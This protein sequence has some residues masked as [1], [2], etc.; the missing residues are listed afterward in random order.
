MS[1]GLSL[2]LDGLRVF[3]T[4][5]VVLSHLAYPRF[6]RGDYNI[7][8]EWNIGSDAVI[9]FF[10]ISGIV[11]AYAAERDG[12]LGQF[13]FK[14]L[15]RLWSV[16]L[17]ALLLTLAFDRLGYPLDPTA[18]PAPFFQPLGLWEMLV[19]GLS[20]T[21][22]WWVPGRLRLGS[23]GP[24]WSLSYE[25][26]Y[27]AL[28]GASVFLSGWL[29]VAVVLSLCL[30][31][32][33]LVLLLMP[34][35]LIGVFLWQRLRAGPD[36]LPSPPLAVIL[37]LAAPLAYV[38]AVSIDVPDL[39]AAITGLAFVPVHHSAVL[40]FSD[41]APWN[42]IIGALAAIH[43]LGMASLLAR[44]R[45]DGRWIRWL[46]GA[47]FSVYVTHYPAL[48]LLDAAL[49][50]DLFGRDM[51]LLVGALTVGL[52]FAEFFERRL[53][54]FRRALRAAMGTP[55]PEARHRG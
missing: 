26:A 41:E 54:A 8:R 15:T 22:E 21:N 38:A 3:A 53:G 28:F 4:L 35:W 7:L 23:N 42:A 37:A 17:P 31:A 32:G 5:A 6:T 18:Y 1:R 27:Y 25:A 10:V 48:H 52:V 36:R 46:A 30:L 51:A 2:W 14:R 33:P 11:I 44:V 19:H 55:P 24:L 20:F 12:T 49:P 43:I 47:S 9:L 40:S 34:A 39:L 45:A 50:E 29:R 16:L 13:A